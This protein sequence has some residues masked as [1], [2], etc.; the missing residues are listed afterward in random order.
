MLQRES[1]VDTWRKGLKALDGGLVVG[2]DL[3]VVSGIH[4]GQRKHAL[5]LQ[6]GL[7]RIITRMS[8]ARAHDNNLDTH[9]VDTG[10]ASDDDGKPTEVPGL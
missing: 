5:L 6:V 4:K 10:K 9:F 1:Q 3:V 8:T 2:P 7:C